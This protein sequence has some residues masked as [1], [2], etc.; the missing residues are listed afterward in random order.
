MQTTSH[1]FRR[2]TLPLAASNAI[3]Q[4]SRA[5]LSVVGP[6]LA[7]EFSLSATELGLLSAW[8]FAAYS[9]SQLPVG[10]ALDLFGARRV[11]FVLGLVA[12][13]GF[14]SF[15]VSSGMTGFVIARMITGVGVSAG[16]IGMMKGNS[17]WYN[18]TE[19]A[20]MTGF[21]MMIGSIGGFLVTAPAHA[22]LPLIGWRGVFWLLAG[23]A[24]V[25]AVWNLLSVRDRPAD[26]ADES[27]PR[28]RLGAEI[29]VIGAIFSSRTFWR[30]VPAVSLMTML[31]FTYQGLWSGP[32]LRDVAGMDGPTR[33]TTLMLYALGL[34]LGSLVMGQAS[35]RLQARGFH[36]LLIP[37]V[38]AGGLMLVEAVLALRPTERLPVTIIWILFPF[39]AAAGPVGYTVIGQMFPSSQVGRVTTAINLLTVGGVFLLQTLI[40][41]ILDLWP[42]TSADGW[43]PRGY[44]AALALTIVLQVIAGGCA[45]RLRARLPA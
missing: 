25:V 31:N 42:R 34:L 28:R 24:V 5:V 7:V 3:T 40:G 26:A 15:A 12:A 10:L 39:F 2:I 6:A 44:S 16:L 14:A 27:P 11:Q 22:L 36:P 41:Q 29:A 37:W 35:S 38:A 1:I 17:R 4:A 23:A 9:L 45:L 18:R 43:D 32:W 19:M 21:A 30:F 13:I 20:A 33:A 8:M